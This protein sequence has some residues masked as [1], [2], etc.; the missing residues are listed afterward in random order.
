MKSRRATGRDFFFQKRRRYNV[1]VE[2]HLADSRNQSPRTSGTDS[3]AV[4]RAAI[5]ALNYTS[6]CSMG[7][8]HKA[9]TKRGDPHKADSAE[10]SPPRTRQGI[11]RTNGS[12]RSDAVAWSAIAADTFPRGRRLLSK[13]FCRFERCRQLY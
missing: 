12:K 3:I 6:T 7:R 11:S 1:C 13:R 5:D 9:R 10:K 8:G 4:V 2:R